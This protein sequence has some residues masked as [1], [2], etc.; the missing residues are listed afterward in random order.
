MP[1]KKTASYR[2]RNAQTG[3]FVKAAYAKRF[4]AVTVREKS[5]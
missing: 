4:P 3:R 5:K 1:K 2:F